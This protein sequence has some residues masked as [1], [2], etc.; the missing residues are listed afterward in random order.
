MTQQEQGFDPYMTE[1]EQGYD[2]YGQF[3]PDGKPVEDPYATVPFKNY[4]RGTK[5]VG[6]PDIRIQPPT[7]AAKPREPLTEA[8]LRDQHLAIYEKS[9]ERQAYPATAGFVEDVDAALERFADHVTPAVPDNKL[10]LRDKP[11]TLTLW[12]D[13]VDSITI[14]LPINEEEG[15]PWRVVNITDNRNL[16]EKY[17]LG[18][19]LLRENDRHG[20]KQFMHVPGTRWLVTKAAPEADI[21]RIRAVLATGTPE[22]PPMKAR[23]RVR[24]MGRLARQ[25]YVRHNAR[26]LSRH[27]KYDY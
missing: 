14:T 13:A 15:T 27:G 10:G 20:A 18:V 9:V 26:S 7:E 21:E 8:Q 5:E 1:Q 17:G 22:R 16:D 25:M 19:T 24:A 6:T 23:D 11:A 4:D 3:T 2:P 12:A